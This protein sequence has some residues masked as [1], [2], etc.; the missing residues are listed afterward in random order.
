MFWYHPA[1]CNFYLP[2]AGTKVSHTSVFCV[3][4]VALL[5]YPLD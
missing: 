5:N 4:V 1:R 2:N 3:V